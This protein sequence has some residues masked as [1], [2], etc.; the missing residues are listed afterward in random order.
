V[1]QS[2]WQ[3]LDILARGLWPFALTVL[4][5]IASQIPLRIDALSPVMPAMALV[6]VYYWAVHRPDLMPLWA[7]FLI[8]LFQDLLSGGPL[9]VGIMMLLAVHAVVSAQ[10][11][12]FASASFFLMWLIFALVAFGAQLFA[13]MLAS[14]LAGM[15]IQPRPAMFQVLMTIAVYPCLAWI[16]AQAQR[17]IL[18]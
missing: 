2:V 14:A 7:V 4:L 9:G 15:V 11:R 18:R 10:R 12:F 3:R 6:A 5:V 16:F 8:G 13:W 1:R 17:S